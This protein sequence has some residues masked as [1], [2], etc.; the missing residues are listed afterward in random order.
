MEQSLTH[1]HVQ[2]HSSPRVRALYL[3]MYMCVR[4]VHT[5]LCVVKIDKQAETDFKE[6]KYK[7]RLE[8]EDDKYARVPVCVDSEIEQVGTD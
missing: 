4:L 2:L 6:F 7:A 1:S 8:H 5:C 3:Y